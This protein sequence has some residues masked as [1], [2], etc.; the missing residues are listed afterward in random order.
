MHLATQAGTPPRVTLAADDGHDDVEGAGVVGEVLLRVVDDILG[1]QVHDELGFAGA[2]D[3]GHDGAPG[4]GYL[5]RV[6]SGAARGADDKGGLPGLDLGGIKG[7]QGRPPG[8]RHRCGLLESDAGRLVG[9][10]VLPSDRV[11]GE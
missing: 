1:V 11:L 9:Q 3:A 8:E 6:G 5:D 7:S 10:L 2:G 4:G